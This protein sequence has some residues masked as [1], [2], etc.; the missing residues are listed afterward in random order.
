MASESNE[1]GRSGIEDRAREMQEW[2]EARAAASAGVHG[3]ESSAW[4]GNPNPR[5]SDRR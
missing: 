3:L 4:Q 1:V 5:N 2:I